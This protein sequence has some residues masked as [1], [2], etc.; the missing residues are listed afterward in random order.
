MPGDFSCQN[1]PL[2]PIAI[3]CVLPMFTC[4]LSRLKTAYDRPKLRAGVLV[5]RWRARRGFVFCLSEYRAA[6]RKG[7]NDR[8]EDAISRT[9]PEKTKERKE[10]RMWN[11]QS[12]GGQRGIPRKW[13]LVKISSPKIS[14]LQAPGAQIVWWSV[15]RAWSIMIT[16]SRVGSA[17]RSCMR[18]CI[19][20]SVVPSMPQ[21]LNQSHR[22]PAA[23]YP[24]P[25]N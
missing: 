13:P 23:Y 10:R 3:D 7:V 22:N 15:G 14:N 17:M 21:T 11:R 9:D 2:G 24:P 25:K 20:M 1:L 5:W 16:C 8:N 4:G 6:R 19:C 12:S 18:P